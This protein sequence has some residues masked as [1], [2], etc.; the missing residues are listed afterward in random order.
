[1]ATQYSYSGPEGYGALN[2]TSSNTPDYF[3]KKARGEF[4]K[5]TSHEY[6]KFAART[7]TG[8]TW[9]GSG[10]LT[11][12]GNYTSSAYAGTFGGET[13]EGFDQLFN[14]VNIKLDSKLRDVKIDLTVTGGEWRETTRFVTGAAARVL[15]SFR[16]LRR[17][18]V[19]RAINSLGIDSSSNRKLIKSAADA[20]LAYSLALR[21]LLMDVQGACEVL[22]TALLKPSPLIIVRTS[23]TANFSIDSSLTDAYTTHKLYGSSRCYGKATVK[24]SDWDL[25]TMGQ[26]GVLNPLSTAWELTPF[27]FVV[28]YFW[29]IGSFLTNIVPPQGVD[30]VD[31]WIYWKTSGREEMRISKPPPQFVELEG[32]AD[33]IQKKRVALSTFPKVQLPYVRRPNFGQLTNVLALLASLTLS[34]S[35]PP[36]RRSQ[37]SRLGI[38]N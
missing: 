9:L 35:G 17:G 3:G 28:D 25:Y 32:R 30:F 29:D 31:G 13:F 10:N 19:K 4:L 26:L 24:I 5:P 20:R 36:L 22:E 18:R 34:D 27:S 16:H 11:T 21:P 2:Y 14:I 33:G 15:N 7:P 23:T 6:Q 1:M 12:L 37:R 8:Q 38:T